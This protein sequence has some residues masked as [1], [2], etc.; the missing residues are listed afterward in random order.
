MKKIMTLVKKDIILYYRMYLL[1]I[2]IA[3]TLIG[4]D[5]NNATDNINYV[6]IITAANMIFIPYIYNKEDDQA[7]RKF[8]CSLPVSFSS[9][10]NA[11]YFLNIVSTL[12]ITF[13]AL[14]VCTFLQKTIDIEFVFIPILIPLFLN[15]LFLFLVYY[16]DLNIARFAM[17]LPFVIFA[18]T[19]KQVENITQL[20]TLIEENE[21]FI[22]VCLILAVFIMKEVTIRL[23]KMYT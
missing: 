14:I 22:S 23:N 6:V 4:I 9:I 11:K 21:L 2:F 7:T 20:P 8:I 13:I 10:V 17:I 3:M 19:A 5:D 16:F 1:L 12:N 15:S 18:M